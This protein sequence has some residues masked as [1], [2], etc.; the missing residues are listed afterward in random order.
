MTC[1]FCFTTLLCLQCLAVWNFLECLNASVAH[2]DRFLLTSMSLFTWL[3]CAFIFHLKGIFCPIILCCRT[4]KGRVNSPILTLL[5]LWYNPLHPICTVQAL[6]VVGLKSNETLFISSGATLF[7]SLN[8]L[9]LEAIYSSQLCSRV[10]RFVSPSPSML[11][12]SL[13]CS[14]SVVQANDVTVTSSA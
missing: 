7:Q 11:E 14:W 13:T 3:I 5:H 8:P 2:T 6:I 12:C 10:W 4:Q 9:T 1:P